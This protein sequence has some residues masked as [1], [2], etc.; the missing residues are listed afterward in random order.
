[1]ATRLGRSR[2]S[3][4]TVGPRVRELD[5]ARHGQQ[6]AIGKAATDN[7]QPDGQSIVRPAGWDGNG[8]M[9]SL[10]ERERERMPLEG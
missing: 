6:V 8:R 3:R 5:E 1:M 7:L 4:T 2:L 10:I 9:P